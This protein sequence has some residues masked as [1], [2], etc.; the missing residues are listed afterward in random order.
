MVNL[1][2]LLDLGF[3]K[4]YPFGFEDDET[5]V[6]Y[7]LEVGGL[8]LLT[9]RDETYLGTDEFEGVTLEGNIV[10]TDIYSL[11]LFVGLI[12]NQITYS[13]FEKKS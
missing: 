5:I 4:Q 13:E 11:K 10:F 7:E 9:F 3:K 12:Q 1:N 2:E 8:T 6:Y